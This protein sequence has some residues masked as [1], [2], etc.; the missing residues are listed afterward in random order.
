MDI[1]NSEDSNLYK[2]GLERT[3][4]IDAKLEKT[5]K[6]ELTNGLQLVG[7]KKEMLIHLKGGPAKNLVQSFFTYTTNT[8]DYCGIEKSKACQLDR[9]HCNKPQFDRN[10]LLERAIETH[11]IDETTPVPIKNILRTFLQYHSG[12]P[13]FVLCKTCHRSYDKK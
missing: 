2:I 4:D 13:L 10:S 12:I 6:S 7:T 1:L 3:Q 11:F 9:A 8:C 5:R